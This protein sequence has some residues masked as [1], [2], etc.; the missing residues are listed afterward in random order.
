MLDLSR[1]LL[2]VAEILLLTGFAT[3]AAATLRRRLLPDFTGGPALLATAVLALALLI[4]TAELLGSFGL[5]Q[6]LPYL[7]AVTAVGLGG[8][9][10]VGGGG[11]GGGWRAGGL[12]SAPPRRS[13]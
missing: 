4:W 11:G 7:A 3:L 13:V 9:R 6:P 12:V 8:S 1:Y 2:G 5:F 10:A